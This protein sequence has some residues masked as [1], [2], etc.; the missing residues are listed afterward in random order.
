MHFGWPSSFSGGAGAFACRALSGMELVIGQCMVSRAWYILYCWGDTGRRRL[1]ARLS[2]GHRG[3]AWRLL[4]AVGAVL[5][6]LL[7]L[8]SECSLMIFP[9]LRLGLLGAVCCF[10][11]AAPLHVGCFLP[12]PAA[13]GLAIVLPFCAVGPRSWAG[14][15]S[16]SVPFGVS[17]YVL[18][19]DVMVGMHQ[20]SGTRAGNPLLFVLLHLFPPLRLFATTTTMLLNAPHRGSPRRLGFSCMCAA[21]VPVAPAVGAVPLCLAPR[22]HR[23]RCDL[24]VVCWLDACTAA[25]LWDCRLWLM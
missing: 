8:V 22:W 3:F 17:C 10:V 9:R 4:V 25:W 12:L 18:Q 11:S 21:R 19:R 7:S 6:L 5:L 15:P 2:F 14:S 13:L 16:L 20:Q 24:S 1:G 23:V